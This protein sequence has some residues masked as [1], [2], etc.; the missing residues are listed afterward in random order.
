MTRILF[1]IA[2]TAIIS[3]CTTPSKQTE[4]E[5]A[6]LVDALRRPAATNQDYI[7]IRC[8]SEKDKKQFAE[9]NLLFDG[10]TQR[11][12]GT[13]FFYVKLGKKS[14][15]LQTQEFRI[16]TEKSD[17][18]TR[19]TRD[20]LVLTDGFDAVIL[21]RTPSAEG[22]YKAKIKSK[23]HFFSTDDFLCRMR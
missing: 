9:L 11:Y 8:D 1:A 2:L 13:V 23:Y 16:H 21:D 22:K 7:K 5:T 19:A 6:P 18:S 15:K 12:S 17:Q 10:S 20:K 14:K 3:A 4:T